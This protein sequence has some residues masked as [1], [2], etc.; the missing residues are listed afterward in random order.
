MRHISHKIAPHR[1]C[2]LQHG[3]IACDWQQR[4]PLR[5]MDEALSTAE[6]R[7]SIFPPWITISPE[8]ALQRSSQLG[9]SHQIDEVL[10]YVSL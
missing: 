9:I 3:D 1:F 8:P 6:P 5:H 4:A 2:L 10:Q 7:L